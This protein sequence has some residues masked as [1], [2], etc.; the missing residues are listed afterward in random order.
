M[1]AAAGVRALR[2]DPLL[3]Y[4]GFQD[5]RIWWPVR[6]RERGHCFCS[7]AGHGG[8][9]MAQDNQNRD[10][11]RE[12]DRD[13]MNREGRAERPE[14]DPV[15]G[16]A[17]HDPSEEEDMDEL[18]EDDREYDDRPEGGTNRRRSIS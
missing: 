17:R 6:V 9:Y 12:D 3:H 16:G 7:R 5:V 2:H 11:E 10:P 15:Q 4:A 1:I 13:R 14:T 18:D 8:S